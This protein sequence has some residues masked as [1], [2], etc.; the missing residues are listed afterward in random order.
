MQSV[1]LQHLY[2]QVLKLTVWHYLSHIGSCGKPTSDQLLSLLI[3][4]DSSKVEL[5]RMET[6]LVTLNDCASSL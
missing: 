3:L 4:I 6:P 1:I 2:Q 5:E